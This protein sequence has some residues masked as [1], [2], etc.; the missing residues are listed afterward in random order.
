MTRRR[1]YLYPSGTVKKLINSAD[2]E[3]KENEETAEEEE[4]EPSSLEGVRPGEL[5]L[6]D[7]AIDDLESEDDEDDDPDGLIDEPTGRIISPTCLQR[8]LL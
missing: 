2:K 8:F 5:T 1:I 3:E 7:R 6:M 4:M